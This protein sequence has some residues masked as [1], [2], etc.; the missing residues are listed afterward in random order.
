MDPKK[1]PALGYLH[2]DGFVYD[3]IDELSSVNSG[4]PLRWIG[5]QTNE[6]FSPQQFDQLASVLRKMGFQED[7]VQVMITKNQ[8]AGD[9]SLAEAWNCD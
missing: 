1:A 5:L 7:A 2:I 4:N 3:Q 9:F 8:K 6:N